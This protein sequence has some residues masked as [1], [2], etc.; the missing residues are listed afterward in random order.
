MELQ[1]HGR[2]DQEARNAAVVALA[3][4]FRLPLLAT[5]GVRYAALDNRPLQDVLT[6]L[7]HKTTLAEAGRLLA[8]NSQ[9]YL[10][11]GKEMERLFRDLPEAIGNTQELADRLGDS[12]CRTWGTSSPTIRHRVANLRVPSYGSARLKAL[13]EGMAS[14]IPKR[15]RQIEHELALIEKLQLAGYFLIVWD[16]VRF[17]VSKG[18]LIQ[19]RGSAA[20]SAVCYALG[21]TAVDPVSMGLLFERFLSEERNEWPDI[22]LDLPSD[23]KP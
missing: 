18:F 9:N 10:R 6:C 20:N 16:I 7:R 2:R 12:P 11:S 19:G 1:R 4:E 22:D 13:S 15:T 8:R 23:T 21:I 14:T 5:N 17:A 3:L